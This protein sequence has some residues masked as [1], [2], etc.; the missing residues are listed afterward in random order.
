MPCLV[1]ASSLSV[2][3]GSNRGL[4]HG[5]PHTLLV[6]KGNNLKFTE[7]LVVY[8]ISLSVLC[9][10]EIFHNKFLNM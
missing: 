6:L 1:C 10:F 5:S 8:Y 2:V 9:T 3:V 7:E 4:M